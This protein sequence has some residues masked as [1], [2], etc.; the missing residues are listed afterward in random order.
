[1]G[2]VLKLFMNLNSSIWSFK[3]KMRLSLAERLNAVVY[4][5]P[6][7]EPLK[8]E[9]ESMHKVSFSFI[10]PPSEAINIGEGIYVLMLKG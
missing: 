5:Q 7:L 8:R 10:K 6:E 3:N 2:K 1:M 9:L 4:A